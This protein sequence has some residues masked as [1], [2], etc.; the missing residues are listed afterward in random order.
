MTVPPSLHGLD[1]AQVWAYENGFHWYAEPRRLA[2]ILAQYDL[3]RSIIHLPGDIAECGVYKGNSLI[4]L[5]T[6]RSI[7][8]ASHS[9]RLVAFDAFGAFPR[10][11]T[12]ADD[13]RFI[14][15]FEG[16]GGPGLDQSAVEALLAAKGLADN[17][18]LVPG[19][20]QDTLPAYLHRHPEQRFALIHLDM[21]IYEPT[22]LALELLWTRIVPGGL[23]LIDD[24]N[25]VAG[26][27]RAIDEFLAA[28]SGLRLEKLPLS[29]I[30]AFIRCP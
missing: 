1:P 18:T 16:A 26:A 4:R 28:H 11:G 25:T 13:L 21:D 23:V 8:E 7:L 27:T 6:F 15:R 20:L 5:A 24:Y 14:D 10:D 22:R 17:L 19:L 3:Y 30:P 9:R 12:D 2:K 29:H